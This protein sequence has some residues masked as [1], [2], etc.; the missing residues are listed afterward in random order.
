MY[1]V[2]RF[3]KRYINIEL[4]RTLPLFI[5]SNFN[6]RGLLPSFCPTQQTRHQSPQS[7]SRVKVKGLYTN[8]ASELI[9]KTMLPYGQLKQ[10]KWN[11]GMRELLA[12][13]HSEL[14]LLILQHLREQHAGV[15]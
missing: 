13:K 3:S 15:Y 5:Y 14:L 9:T 11:L 6:A 10:M 4:T 12:Q 8:Y 1:N 7:V 2:I